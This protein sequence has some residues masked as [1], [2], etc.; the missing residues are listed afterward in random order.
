M[1][2]AFTMKLHFSNRFLVKRLQKFHLESPVDGGAHQL[3][4]DWN[5]CTQ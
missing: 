5:Y 1:P 3:V 2:S 4:R